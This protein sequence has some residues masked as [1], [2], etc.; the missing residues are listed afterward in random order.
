MKEPSKYQQKAIMHLSGPAEVIAGPG[1]GKTTTIIQRILY[2]VYQCG[3]SPRKILVITYT[4]AAAA[5][6][7]S[8]Y[9]KAAAELVHMNQASE[10]TKAYENVNFG[11]FHSIC[12]HML[13]QS[14][15]KQLSLIGEREK[16]EL[17]QALL[18]NMGIDGNHLY[19]TVSAVLNEISRGKNLPGDGQA[20]D[21]IGVEIAGEVAYEIYLKVKK[22]YEQYLKEQEMVDFDD[23]I[24]DCLKLFISHPEVLRRYQQQFE[25][26]LAD[27]FQD[28][29]F[30]QY[31][32]LKLL[33]APKNNLFVVGDDDQAIYG[34]RGASPGIM[35]QFLEDYPLGERI[36]LTENYRSGE[37]IVSLAGRVIRRNKERFEKEFRPIKKGGRVVLTCFNGRKQEEEALVEKLR[38][39]SRQELE[40]TAVILRTNLAADQYAELL[41]ISGIAVKGK[42]KRSEDIF[43]SFIMEDMIAFLSFIYLGNKRRDFI[44]F[45]NKPNRFLLREALLEERVTLLQLQRYYEKNAELKRKTESLWRQLM[46]AGSLQTSLAISLFRNTLGYN[47]YLA[48]KAVDV[49]QESMYLKQADQI[50]ECLKDYIPGTDLRRF[51]ARK[52]KCMGERSAPII[53]G[54]GVSVLTMHGAKGLEFDRVLLPDVNEGIMPAK[55]CVTE[56]SLEEERRLLYVAI[57]R[58]R[59]ELN[60]Y[61]TKERGRKLS[62]YLEGLIPHQ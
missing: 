38:K 20:G 58:A 36:M 43:H 9:Q 11:T 59:S 31:H 1:S 62:P 46:L 41:A 53:S 13:R 30:P 61:Y 25:Y 56:G 22:G 52:E 51:A 26:I 3:I 21:N 18:R 23:M 57:T 27:E 2:L 37:K 34:F 6:M 16:R 14:V 33:A 5:E 44:A 48:E 47:D 28:I 7:K 45:M 54:E 55:K 60:I 4:K 29:N 15:P 40:E 32:I 19:D 8:R 50:Q 24:T 10:S 12:F 42:Q 17:V 35:K 49:R 39:L